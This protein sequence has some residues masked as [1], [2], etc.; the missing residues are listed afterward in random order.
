MATTTETENWTVQQ[1]TSPQPVE[2]GR[3]VW[4][5]YRPDGNIT[6]YLGYAD[7]VSFSEAVSKAKERMA[8]WVVPRIVIESIE[9]EDRV[10]L[11]TVRG[12]VAL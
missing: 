11:V 4:A 3:K 9:S 1:A 7:Q 6:R 2:K 8:G 5:L 12:E 10:K